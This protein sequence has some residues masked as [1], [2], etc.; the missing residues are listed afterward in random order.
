MEADGVK[1]LLV[2]LQKLSLVQL[3]IV[4]ANFSLKFLPFNV[5]SSMKIYTKF[6]LYPGFTLTSQGIFDSRHDSYDPSIDHY[7][8]FKK[9]SIYL[10]LYDKLN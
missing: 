5:F 4:L 10:Y 6:E 1:I 2:S 8:F 7:F 3:E 9:M